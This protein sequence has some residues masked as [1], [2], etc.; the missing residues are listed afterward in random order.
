MK[1]NTGTV[2][3]GPV[4]G[5]QGTRPE[6]P[7]KVFKLARTLGKILMG[8]SPVS[9]PEAKFK[10]LGSPLRL[11]P[12]VPRAEDPCPSSSLS[13]FLAL[14][15]LPLGLDLPPQL[16]SGPPDRGPRPWA[17]QR[18]GVKASPEAGAP[19]GRNRGGSH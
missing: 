2:R 11:T 4:G 18:K 19:T 14:R 16:P 12:C 10:G 1:A 17:S 13:T 8:S 15:R 7:S 9:G 3:F 5:L 6:C